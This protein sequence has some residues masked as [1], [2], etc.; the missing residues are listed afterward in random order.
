MNNL[1]VLVFLKVLIFSCNL[2]DFIG[3]GLQFF[4]EDVRHCFSECTVIDAPNVI[5][6]QAQLSL[7][8]GGLGLC[9]LAKHSSSAYISSLST[10][11]I[12][13]LFS[14]DKKNC[15]GILLFIF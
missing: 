13:I 6:Q 1:K 7:S 15:I 12:M 5:W 2:S 3:E 4:D 11:C 8:R 9:S 10:S 14:N